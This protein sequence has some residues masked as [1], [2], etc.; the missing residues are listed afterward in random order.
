[1]TLAASAHLI[2]PRPHLARS[3]FY[4]AGAT[5]ITIA[6]SPSTTSAITIPR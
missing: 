1:M 3:L 5:K 4:A 6:A 2:R